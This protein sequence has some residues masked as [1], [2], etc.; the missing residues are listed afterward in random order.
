MTESER[1]KQRKSDFL[2]TFSGPH[3]ERV[4]AY[5]SV[6]CLKRGST[7]IVGSPDKS[8]FNEGARAVILEID[9][10]LEYD[11]STLEEAGETD[12]IEPERK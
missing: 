12:N 9:H 10:W 8:A 7:F 6:F 3:G 5:L 4:L 1:I 2:Q 11:L